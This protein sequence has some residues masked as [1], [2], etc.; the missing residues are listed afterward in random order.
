[1][2]DILSLIGLLITHGLATQIITNTLYVIL[3]GTM[4]TQFVVYN[5]CCGRNPSDAE[6][7]IDETREEDPDDAVP[8]Q[9]FDLD[10]GSAPSGIAMLS[11]MAATATAKTMDWSTPYNKDNL[12]GTLFGW[13]GCIGYMLSGE[14]QIHKNCD[15]QSVDDV[16]PYYL[17]LIISGNATYT[18]AVMIRSMDPSYLWQQAPWIIGSIWP[19][20]ADIVVCFQMCYYRRKKLLEYTD[21]QFS[22][23][24]LSEDKLIQ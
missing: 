5:Y 22:L 24:R 4:F 1:M 13:C 23:P 2:G 7:I 15:R 8:D 19:M 6:E 12:I 16:S 9:I 14:P 21:S 3:D 20:C 18:I 10:K 11:A 17:A